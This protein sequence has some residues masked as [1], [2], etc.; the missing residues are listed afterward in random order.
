MMGC[1]THDLSHLFQIF[2]HCYLPSLEQ[3][4]HSPAR[5]YNFLGR[6]TVELG[7][8]EDTAWQESMLTNNLRRISH[9]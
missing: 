3:T 9:R 7:R 4:V 6:I 2:I 5:N 8:I 1:N